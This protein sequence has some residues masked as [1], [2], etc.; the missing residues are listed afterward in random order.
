M[1]IAMIHQAAK[2]PQDA[3]NAYNAV[4]ETDPGNVAAFRG[5][6][7]AFLS[8][9]NQG[10]AVADYD[11]ALKVEPKNTGVLNNLAWVLATSPKDDLR[12]GKRAIELATLACEVT[13]YKQAHILSTLAAGYAGSGDFE[14]A[15]KWS[16]KAVEAGPDALKSQLAKELQSY[17][18]KKPW[19]EAMPPTDEAGDDEPRSGE[20]KQLGGRRDALLPQ[21]LPGFAGAWYAIYLL[22]L[23]D[24]ETVVLIQPPGG[25]TLAEVQERAWLAIGKLHERHPEGRVVAVTHNFVILTLLALI[26]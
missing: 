2:H 7:D 22:A 26:V 16:K 20:K 6:G 24:V 13:E 4:L 19:R 10:E 9:G 1:Q 21:V 14:T 15:I 17:E 11:K 8:L 25:E 5:R 3:V 23:W 12:D 18:E